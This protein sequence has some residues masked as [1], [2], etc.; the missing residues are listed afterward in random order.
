VA[1]AGDVVEYGLGGFAAG[2]SL[3]TSRIE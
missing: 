2:S 3:S 1:V